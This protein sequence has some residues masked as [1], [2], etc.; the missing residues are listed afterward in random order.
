MS[1]RLNPVLREALRLEKKKA[2]EREK[3]KRKLLDSGKETRGNASHGGSFQSKMAETAHAEILKFQEAR[4]GEEEAGDLVREDGGIGMD[5]RPCAVAAIEDGTEEFDVEKDLKELESDEDGPQ[6]A[7]GPVPS[8]LPPTA[9]AGPMPMPAEGGEVMAYP[10]V[11]SQ[12]E[13]EEIEEGR[14]ECIPESRT[15]EYSEEVVPFKHEVSMMK[16]CRSVERYEKLN[17]ISEGTYGVVYRAKER[18]TGRICALK[19]MKLEQ[20]NSGFPLTYVRE[21]NVLLALE[22]PNIV[23]VS[24]VVV[25]SKQSDPRNDNVFLVMEYADH[26]LRSVM[27]KRMRKPFT[28]AEVKCLMLQLL[29]GVAYLHENWVIHRDLK[30]ANILY[31]NKGQLKIC[32]FGLA[33]LYSSFPREYTQLVVTLWYRAPELLLG[34][35]M[36]STPVDIWSVGCIMGELLLKKP[37]I[38]GKTDMEQLG[39]IFAMV[40]YPSEEDV[41]RFKSFALW[42][43]IS[44]KK[45]GNNSHGQLMSLFSSP[46]ED[47]GPLSDIGH[48]GIDL[49]YKLLALNPD[50]RISAD[51]ALNHPWF[52]E[53]PLP[54]DPS[55][56]P[57]F[58][59]TNESLHNR[60]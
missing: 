37:L 39:L 28:V 18:E 57:T 12:E 14:E 36:Y 27:E 21:I 1:G 16:G 4:V 9:V 48:S 6:V 44:I 58:K 7:A 42:D 33:R 22:H 54:K 19:R 10:E 20:E 50:K 32:D 15:Q 23:N 45:R 29:A 8:E 17:R 47:Y 24:E 59:S 30:T 25:G 31:T 49:L 41:Q 52:K 60:I 46:T 53:H 3:K 34:E 38:P 40:G 35:R 55:M 11:S 13:E 5:E 43:K 26:D 51:E 56:M 2:L